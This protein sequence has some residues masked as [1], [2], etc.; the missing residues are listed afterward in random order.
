MRE[1]IHLFKY[2][3]VRPLAPV[4]GGFLG[5][6][7][8][9][10]ERFDVLVPMPL[11]WV[12]RWRRGFNQSYL[13][14]RELSRRTGIPVVG[15]LRR[16]R[17]TASQASLS[18][19]ERR[20]NVRGAFEPRRDADVGGL[21][22]LLVDDV[23]TTGATANAC[24]AVLKRAGASCVTVLTLARADRRILNPAAEPALV[25]GGER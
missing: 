16:K 11:H 13:L 3:R 6:A 18:R 9:R 15:A 4:L 24:A 12:R 22:V 8:P 7:L 10:E 25:V 2:G 14:A 5:A 17:S 19:A 20:R 1:L 23:L 21:R